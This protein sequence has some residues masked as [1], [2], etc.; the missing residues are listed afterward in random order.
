M[1]L[2]LTSATDLEKEAQE[3]ARRV[4]CGTFHPITYSRADTKITMR[5]VIQHNAVLSRI[6]NGD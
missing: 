1:P 6:C 3:M 5:Q 4:T 2:T